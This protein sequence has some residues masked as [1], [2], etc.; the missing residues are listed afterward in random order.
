MYKTQYRVMFVLNCITDWSENLTS[1]KDEHKKGNKKKKRK[2]E[3]EA[4]WESI[5]SETDSFSFNIR[6]SVCNT[7]VAAYDEDEVFHFFNVLSSYS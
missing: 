1:K 7:Q 6:C 4:T 3:M 2:G 5:E